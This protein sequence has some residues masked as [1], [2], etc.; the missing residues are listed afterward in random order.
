MYRDPQ[1]GLSL[2]SDSCLW[3]LSV[4]LPL[5][6]GQ[7]RLLALEKLSISFP[8]YL[9]IF[10]PPEKLL[11]PCSA[12][13]ATRDSVDF[14]L[15]L[16]HGVFFHSY[17]CRAP[18]HHHSCKARPDFPCPSL[19]PHVCLFLWCWINTLHDLGG[20]FLMV[21]WFCVVQLHLSP[22]L[23]PLR[24]FSF[25]SL[26]IRNFF[27]L[28]GLYALIV[29]PLSFEQLVAFLL[30]LF[31]FPLGGWQWVDGNRTVC[32]QFSAPWIYLSCPVFISFGELMTQTAFINDLG[33]GGSC[34]W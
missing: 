19:P 32:C 22:A 15:L 8:L 1:V 6:P 29:T 17:P 28:K 24:N 14:G 10:F 25:S 7:W 16:H 23:L 18:S 34:I 11:L 21:L 33:W 5:S 27:S 20:L 2:L 30:S 9:H 26:F 31:F 3:L 4:H 12:S 13:T